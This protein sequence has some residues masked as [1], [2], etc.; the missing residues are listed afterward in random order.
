MAVGQNRELSFELIYKETDKKIFSGEVS[1][2]PCHM[3]I[4]S[5]TP[6]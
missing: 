2:C 6:R 1:D 3:R 4:S 5:I